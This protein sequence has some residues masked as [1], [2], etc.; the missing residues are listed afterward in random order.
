MTRAI[1]EA[2]PLY[3]ARRAWLALWGQAL[4]LAGG[5]LVTAT[6]QRG[7]NSISGQATG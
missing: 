2:E 7:T 4:E 1:E 3:L 5:H 6:Q